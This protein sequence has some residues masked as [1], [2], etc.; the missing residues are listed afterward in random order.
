MPIE[1]SLTVLLRQECA[2]LLTGLEPCTARH[3]PFVLYP[4]LT[5]VLASPGHLYPLYCQHQACCRYGATNPPETQPPTGI[6][7]FTSEKVI[8]GR[9]MLR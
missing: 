7:G 4:R 1:E 3:P 5:W 9:S 8:Q 6:C 2:G